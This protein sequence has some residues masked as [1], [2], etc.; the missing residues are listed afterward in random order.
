LLNSGVSCRP[1]PLGCDGFFVVVV[2]VVNIFRLAAL[3]EPVTLKM[4]DSICR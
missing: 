1:T 2:V 3:Y 4:Q